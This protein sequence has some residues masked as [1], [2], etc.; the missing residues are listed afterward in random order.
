[1]AIARIETQLSRRRAELALRESEERYALAVR[2]ANDGLWDW[3]LR[4]NELYFSPRWKVMLGFDE[5]DIGNTPDE[6]LTRI[7]PEEVELVKGAIDAHIAGLTRPL[8]SEH[9]IKRR[10]GTFLWMRSRGLA[11][12]DG[13]GKA[14]RMA[15]SQTDITDGK[16]ADAL[17]GLPNRILF[18]D[19]LTHSHRPYQALRRTLCAPSCSWTSIGSS[20]STT[21]WDTWPA[22]NCWW[23]WRGE[24]N[25]ACGPATW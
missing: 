4:T 21:A 17:T 22:T 1:M 5:A 14:Y 24:S 10:D 16:I 13:A 12:R 15:G 19:R 23:G 7:H 8:R 18:N 2:G 11:V 9:R 25:D 20:W 6:W 3:N